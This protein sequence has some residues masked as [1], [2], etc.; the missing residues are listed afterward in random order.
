MARASQR[1]GDKGQVI[2][3]FALAL[4]GIVAM[5]GLVLDGGSAFEQ[6]REEQ[7]VSDLA[8]MAGAVAYINTGGSVFNKTAAADAAARSVATANGYTGGADAV[9]VDVSVAGGAN[10]ATVRVSIG[11]PHQN[12]FSGVVGM[13]TWDV[14][15]TAQAEVNERPN[16]VNG[17]MPLLFNEEA[18]PTALCDESSGTCIPE[19]YQLPGTGNEDVPQDATQFNWTIFCEAS[20]SQCS[21]A[22]SNGVSDLIHQNGHGDTVYIG[23]GIGPLNAGSHTTLF[24][25]LGAHTGGTFPV[26]IVNDDGDMVGFAYFKLISIE[27]GSQKVIRGYFVSPVRGAELVYNP[28]KP[29]A[30]LATGGI[31]LELID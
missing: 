3:I 10:G 18:F 8:S 2:V 20:G 22:D 16:G 13:P 19:V 14:S 7:N 21:Q 12:T 26:P 17:A 24:G 15:T 9:T 1:R 29:G 6:R 11:K 23:D 28:A 30:T 27:G 5:V 4:V 31:L 25:D